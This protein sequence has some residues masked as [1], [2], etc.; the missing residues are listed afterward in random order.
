MGKRATRRGSRLSQHKPAAGRPKVRQPPLRQL[1]VADIGWLRDHV[2]D[3]LWTGGFVTGDPY[4]GMLRLSRV[5]DA[6]GAFS[7]ASGLVVAP[8]RSILDGSLTSLERVPI[9]SRAPLLDHLRSQGLTKAALPAGFVHAIRVYADAPGAWISALAG[10]E[11]PDPDLGQASSYMSAVVRSLADGRGRPATV[12]KGLLLRETMAAGRISFPRDFGPVDELPRY[13]FDLNEEERAGVESFL[14]ATFGAISQSDEVHGADRRAWAQ[15]FWTENG[16]LFPCLVEAEAEEPAGV[17]ADVPD[18]ALEDADMTDS[19]NEVGGTG[20]EALGDE[21]GAIWSDFL[22]RSAEV[23][24]GVYDPDRYEVTTGLVAHGL[25]VAIAVVAHP[26]TWIGEFSAP[27]LRSL[28]E[29][30]INLAWLA[31]A[32]K[33]DAAIYAKFKDF[34][35]GHAKLMKLH[36][37]EAADRIPG[38]SETLEDLVESIA[39]EVNAEVTEEL[40]D[41]SLEAT[42]SGKDLRKMALSAGVEDLYRLGLAPMSSITHSE[43]PALARYALEYCRNPLHRLHRVPRQSLSPSVRPTAGRSAVFLAEQL[44]DAYKVAFPEDHPGAVTG[45]SHASSSQF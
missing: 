41:I 6:I 29:I 24:P 25:R 14:R 5:L 27:L 19:D 43:W 9:E 44:L 22:Q 10:S 11:L 32:E 30:L 33:T 13:P 3:Q 4:A 1:P 31:I 20:P 40:Q 2:P 37:E 38:G 8:D 26:G 21:L 16:R 15:R 23:D 35:R 17:V 34:G 39:D 18:R 28:V 45:D 36:L 42:F 7:K 12:I